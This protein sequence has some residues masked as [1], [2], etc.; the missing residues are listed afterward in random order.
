MKKMDCVEQMKLLKEVGWVWKSGLR[1]VGGG[2]WGGVGLVK[3]GGV[4]LEERG[5]VG[6]VE[7]GEM[8]YE[9]VNLFEFIWLFFPS[10]VGKYFQKNSVVTFKKNIFM[11]GEAI[12]GRSIRARKMLQ[13]FYK[14][15]ILKNFGKKTN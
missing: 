9:G 14:N 1:E 3:G 7:G 11:E 15:I 10:I 4:G 6:L 13:D 5:G 8:R 12:E 2:R